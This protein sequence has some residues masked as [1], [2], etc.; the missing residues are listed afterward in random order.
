MKSKS[1]TK[2][3]FLIMVLLVAFITGAFDVR[4]VPVSGKVKV[5]AQ[6]S[7][8]YTW[9]NVVTGGGGGFVPGIV[10]NPT[11]PNLIYAR[12]DIGGAYRWN[13]STSRWIPLMD[14]VSFDEWNL[15]GVDSLAT[16]PV[17]PNRLYVLAGTY[18][19]EWTT[20]NGEILRSTDRGNTFQRTSLPFKSGGNMPGRSMGER[21]AIDPNQN[22][23]LYL[24][25]RSG[26]GL[27]RSTNFGSTWAKV[28][29]FPNPGNY[30]QQPGDV[31]LGDNVGVVWVTFD[32]RT[33]SLSN[34]T[35]TIY[36]GVADKGTSIYRSTNGGTTWAA[37]PGQPTGFLPH[38]GVLTSNGMLYITYSDGA[39][40]YDGTKGD[41]W[42]FNT[43]NG[44]WT[45][46]SPV[47]SSSGDNYF[48]YGGLAVDAQHP[49]TLMVA[50]LNSWW[51]DTI[52]FR[53]TNA[54]VT[55]TRIWDWAGFPSRT[56][57]Y[58]QNI[59]AAPWLAFTDL[60]PVP[61]VPSPKLGWMVGDL[62]IDPFNSNRMLYGTGAT[63]YG[64]DDLTDWD[65]GGSIDITVKAQGLEEMA[66]LDLISPPAGAPLLSGIGDVN[67]FRHDNLNVA[68]TRMFNTPSFAS[69]SLDYAELSPSF[70]ARAGNVDRTANPGVNR[71]GFSFDGGTS[72][73]QASSEPG[74]V[75]GG[76]TIAAAA[77]ASRVVWSPDGASP[78]FSANNGSSWT[79]CV[80]LP[81]GARVAADRV[82]PN[83]FY[84]FVNG[85]FY[86]STNGGANFTATVGTGLPTSA[87]FKAVP[88]REGD[89]WLAGGESGL[90]HSTNSGTS[91]T[92]LMN[93]EESDV[94]GFGMAAPGQNY[95][96]LYTSA[97]INGIRGIFRSDDA[98]ATWTR[99]ND[100]QHQYG[101]TNSAI[102]G[103]PRVYGR[104]YIGTNGRGIIYGEPA[105]APS[106]DF[107][108]SA[109]P[110]SLTVNRGASGTSTITISRLNGFNGSVAL[111]ASGLPSGVTASFS[112]ASTTGT[113][114]TLTLTASS[115]AT[116]GAAT[117][118][119]TGTGG[120]LTRT[121][122]INLTVNAPPVPDFTLAANPSTLTV[123]RGA[124]GTSTITITRT[125]GFTG[126]VALSGSGLPSGVT[127]G[128]NPASVTGTSSTLTLTASATAT[129]GAATV[130][131]TGTSGS[132]TR[133]TQI[134]LT[135]NAPATPNFTLAASPATLTVNRGASGTST[136]TITRT[137]GFTSSVALSASGL[138]SGV[139]ASFNPAST[140]GTS[141]TLTLTASSTATLGAATITVTGTG[142]SLTRT[143]TIGLTVNSGTSGT[144]GV[145]VTPAVT[146]SSPWFNE[147]VIRLNN[148]GT[149]TALTVTIVVQ[150]TTG[151]S[152]GGQFNTVG[153]QILQTNNSTATTITY[154]FTLATGQ[155][156]GPGSNWTFAT[157]TNGNGTVHPTAGDT[158][159]VTYTT[160]GVTFTQTGTF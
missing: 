57:R 114:S 63:I 83:K 120:S 81:A 156:L 82:N 125:G 113:T 89:I 26:N 136:I 1:L 87:K 44:T 92:Q 32:P 6:T 90:W 132:L 103:D 66:V 93:V 134:N 91:F 16:D 67:G 39:G 24:G 110:S 146:S 61:P 9:R 4:F 155:T 80:G 108:L 36:V 23:I 122:P 60:N 21:L 31:Y 71:A 41:V 117:I 46:I 19:N 130:T 94:I 52:L 74:G 28:T 102:T 51:P 56:L 119:V 98:G 97:Q 37:V 88:G 157:Q 138:P 38:H 48:G 124:S 153:G 14:W 34:A 29:S 43:A 121:T 143:T 7:Q 68:P 33:G 86:V 159:T 22:N 2:S 101:T 50:A 139:T 129:L 64:C 69:V 62:E 85:T 149:L 99:I 13:P 45:L 27:W 144:G 96:A 17:E 70:I 137:G 109:N 126:S 75:S 152:F 11:E 79:A 72:W 131:V 142:G 95:M 40:P 77:N 123:T 135:V 53:S 20:M 151:I 140:T 112:P 141:S 154:Q 84:G 10:F 150:R 55:W 148:T 73:F 30:V 3:P 18:T 76:G 160:G 105:S 116:L 104:V 158:F 5:Y 15:L 49:D 54:G 25:A 100:D 115:T 59:S 106:P 47:P 147:Q 42:R 78:H 107:S 12:T 145:T 8:P 133:T 35:Q 65:T 111:T 118:T 127:A 58:T 128:F